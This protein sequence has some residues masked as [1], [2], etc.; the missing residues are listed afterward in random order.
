MLIPF[1]NALKRCQC[2]YTQNHIRC[3]DATAAI[4]FITN[5]Y[6]MAFQQF[7]FTF[8]ICSFFFFDFS[9]L[10]KRYAKWVNRC[11]CRRCCCCHS[12]NEM[13][14][15]LSYLRIVCGV[16]CIKNIY[17]FFFSRSP[18]RYLYIEYKF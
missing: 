5:S 2:Q 1:E 17:T 14:F 16:Y 13:M 8:F 6:F 4:W 15:R 3:G 11:W 18:A 12:Q 7:P 10:G 9:S